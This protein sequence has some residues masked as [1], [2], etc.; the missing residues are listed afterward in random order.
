MTTFLRTE[1]SKKEIVKNV[2]L[3][4]RVIIAFDPLTRNLQ[5]YSGSFI[6]IFSLAYNL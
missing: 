3:L 6:P 1:M 4:Y 5:A 2:C